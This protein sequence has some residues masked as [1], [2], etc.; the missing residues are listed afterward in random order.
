GCENFTTDI[1][2]ADGLYEM[3]KLKELG[4]KTFFFHDSVTG[5]EISAADVQKAATPWIYIT[6][7]KQT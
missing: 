7:L 3:K 5:A 2:Y 6:A 4:F 1:F